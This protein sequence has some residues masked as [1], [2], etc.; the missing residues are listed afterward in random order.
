MSTN[1]IELNR[2]RFRFDDVESVW[3]FGYGSL[4]Y[5]VDFPF[6]EQRA[7]RIHGWTRRFWQ[8]S[9]DHRGTP[10]SPGRVVTLVKQ[11]HA[12]CR[13][14]AYRISPEVFSHLDVRE[15]NGYLRFATPMVFDDGSS[16]EG[17]VYIATDDN[18]AYLGPADEAVIARQIAGASGPSGRNDE[19]LL[20]LADALRELGDDDPHV[21][22]IEQHLT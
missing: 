10:E 4:I 19:Y 2:S 11:A 3:L 12:S 14:I 21:F 22:E 7:A 17:L 18:E 6:L 1:T 8:G 16:E 20:K 13:G 15:K 5:K 9:H